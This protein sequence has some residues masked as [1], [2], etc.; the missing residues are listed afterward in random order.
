ML[1][2]RPVIS[3]LDAGTAAYLDYDLGVTWQTLQQEL[4]HL[5]RDVHQHL[6]RLL[7]HHLHV[8][9]LRNA[10]VLAGQ[11]LNLQGAGR[12]VEGSTIFHGVR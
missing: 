2:L 10:A 8:E 1:L 6:P 5:K 9:L 11:A 3:V 4:G 7:L 12:N